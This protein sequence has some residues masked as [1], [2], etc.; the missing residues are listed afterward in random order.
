MIGKNLLL[1]GAM[2]MRVGGQLQL[3]VV[4]RSPIVSQRIVCKMGRR[5]GKTMD[6]L[7]AKNGTTTALEQIG[8]TRC[9]LFG[10]VLYS[11]G[12]LVATGRTMPGGCSSASALYKSVFPLTGHT[13]HLKQK[14]FS[15]Q[16][17]Q[18]KSNCLTATQLL[19]PLTFEQTS[20]K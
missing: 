1:T 6:I 4:I 18:P 15:L 20:N 3:V 5:T 9:M 17:Q 7:E 2:G 14:T 12:G 13:P 11:S 16:P 10:H 8:M 19:L